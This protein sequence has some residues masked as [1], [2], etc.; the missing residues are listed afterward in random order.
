MPIPLIAVAAALAAGGTLVP[1]AAG[2]VIVTLAAGGGYV[3]GTY[4]STAAV[5][6]IIALATASFATGA[7]V[8]S[9]AAASIIGG[10]GI[11]GTTIG[12]TGLTGVLMS[13]GVIPSTPIIVPV[14]A[15]SLA[16]GCGYTSYRF[17][18]LKR[19]LRTSDSDEEAR[20]TEGEAKLI[21]R[22]LL[23][24]HERGRLK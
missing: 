24:L 1:H 6:S 11:F 5:A 15:A 16:A 19:K 18:R 12:A 20:F 4:L 22:V 17:I 21:G 14:L 23:A 13:A 10:A 9:G 3:A 8:L 7:A 2:G